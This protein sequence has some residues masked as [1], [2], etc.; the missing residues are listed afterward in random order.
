MFPFNNYSF[1]LAMFILS[2]I[3]LIIY[4]FYFLGD[5]STD[6]E[7]EDKQK[8]DETETETKINRKQSLEPE[9]SVRMFCC[10]TKSSSRRL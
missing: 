3:M 8:I 7:N 2:F 4:Q 6:G 9:N 10:Y 1:I 5:D